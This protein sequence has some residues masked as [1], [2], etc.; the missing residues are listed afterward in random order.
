M[1]KLIEEQGALQLEIDD[2]RLWDLDT[3]IDV[4]MD[5]LRCPEPNRSVNT[6]SGGEKR[7]VALTRLLL[8]EPDILL[9]DEPTNHLDAGSVAWLERF[10]DDYPGL[11]IAITHDR[12]FLDN[13]A[14]YILEITEGRCIPFKGNY[15]D[16]LESKAGRMDLEDKKQ[17][18]ENKVI[19]RELEWL[20]GNSKN[21]K[22]KNK[23]RKG[24]A[25]AMIGD[26]QERQM[27]QRIESGALILPEAQVLHTRHAI[28]TVITFRNLKIRTN[29]NHFNHLNVFIYTGESERRRRGPYPLREPQHAPGRG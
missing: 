14:G 23:S 27:N 29:S 25:E 15:G 26:K 2:K 22:G 20:R 28:V 13:V 9:L 18:A 19:K 5:A 11:V 17:K 4:A 7:R 12:Y 3:R 21:S 24:K 16:W 6:L 10:L 8:S 1:N